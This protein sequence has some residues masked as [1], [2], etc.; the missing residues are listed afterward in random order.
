M[1]NK[2]AI[3]FVKRSLNV[4]DYGYT[5][6]KYIKPDIWDAVLF[7]ELQ[8]L[9]VE[10]MTDFNYSRCFSY[11][12]L[13]DLEL[14]NPFFSEKATNEI[15]DRGYI[16]FISLKISAISPFFYLER[17]MYSKGKEKLELAHIKKFRNS[18]LEKE[19]VRIQN[20]LEQH[21][22]F[23][24]DPSELKLKL[25]NIPLEDY[26]VDQVTYFSYLFE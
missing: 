8:N 26:E 1:E 12:I 15:M 21:D 25:P 16:E 20:K 10:R 7:S 22:L 24:I 4:G 9:T 13:E 5:L 6:R 23:R 2:E 3:N 14:K 19:M 11:Y 17:A 18:L